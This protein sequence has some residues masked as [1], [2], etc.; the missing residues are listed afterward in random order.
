MK[1]VGIVLVS[2]VLAA[3]LFGCAA[4][5]VNTVDPLRYYDVGAN[6]PSLEARDQG[7]KERWLAT[8]Q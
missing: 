8:G 5:P 1:P 3:S 6:Y 2:V 4:K 7:L